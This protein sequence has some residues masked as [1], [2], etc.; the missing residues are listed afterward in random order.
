M[1][2]HIKTCFSS[3]ITFFEDAKTIFLAI[4]QL[5]KVAKKEGF[6][7]IPIDF[8]LGEK[9]NNNFVNQY[10]FNNESFFENK[11]NSNE[12]K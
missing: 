9:D 11:D 3:P 1:T 5:V 8:V 10:L 2:R 7:K 12:D 4:C 6:E